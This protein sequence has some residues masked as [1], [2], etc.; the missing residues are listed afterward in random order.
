MS[1]LRTMVLAACAAFAPVAAAQTA[2]PAASV[3]APA[4]PA[5]EPAPDIAPAPDPAPPVDAA[6]AA[7]AAPADPAALLQF[8]RDEW[9]RGAQ[10]RYALTRTVQTAAQSGMSDANVD[11][12]VRFDPRKPLGERWTVVSAS[13]SQRAIERNLARE[14]RLG[15]ATD[16]VLLLPEGEFTLEN[17]TLKEAL[18]EVVTYTFTPKMVPEN[19]ANQMGG[20]LI[21]QLEGE[22][23][24]ARTGR[25][26]RFTLRTPAAGLRAMMI[27]KVKSALISRGFV[28]A[29]GAAVVADS[30]VQTMAMS[31]MLSS[32]EVTTTSRFSDVEPI[33]DPAAV[34][35]IAARE[36]TARQARKR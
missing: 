7:P 23:E 3:A 13:R 31:A 6:T 35:E 26:S 16:H 1:M 15:I 8:A 21:E 11:L 25:V 17:L 34:A 9:R 5:V 14:D 19:T 22:L 18:P 28:P 10:C 33:C 12:V 20:E 27:V 30:D 29:P 2:E 32:T 36:A 24:V 4:A